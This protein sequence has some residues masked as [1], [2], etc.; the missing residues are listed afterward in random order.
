LIRFIHELFSTYPLVAEKIKSLE[1][2]DG[3]ET[4]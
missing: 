4:D 1:Q 3:I 2:M